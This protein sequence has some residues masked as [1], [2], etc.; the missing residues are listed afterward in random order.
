MLVVVVGGLAGLHTVGLN[1]E[2]GIQALA[3][4]LL[5]SASAVVPCPSCGTVT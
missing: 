1:K 5:L 2:R 4:P 3:L